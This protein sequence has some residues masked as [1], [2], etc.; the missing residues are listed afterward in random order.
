MGPAEETPGQ[1]A[2]EEIRSTVSSLFSRSALY[3]QDLTQAALR[4]LR[5]GFHRFST[6]TGFHER[7]LPAEL[8]IRPANPLHAKGAEVYPPLLRRGSLAVRH[9]PVG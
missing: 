5:H 7:G 6:L 4:R 2:A 1:A 3:A 8:H 9:R